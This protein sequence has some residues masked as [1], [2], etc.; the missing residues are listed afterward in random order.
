MRGC[1]AGGC[2]DVAGGRGPGVVSRVRHGGE[3][4]LFDGCCL[5]PAAAEHT[6]LEPFLRV[7]E[8]LV[9][10]GRGDGIAGVRGSHSPR[11]VAYAL[12][13]VGRACSGVECAVGCVR[14]PLHVA[15]E[16]WLEQCPLGA[17][18]IEASDGAKVEAFG[19]AGSLDNL[20]GGGW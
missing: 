1:A 8:G 6:C 3:D 5:R 2:G 14:I 4:F 18:L 7:Q 15:S 11:L 16:R 10:V 12:D 13:E 20:V 17:D 19:E 9:D